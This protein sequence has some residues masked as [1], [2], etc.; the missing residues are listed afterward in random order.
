M[1][2]LPPITLDSDVDPSD[3]ISA[4][5]FVNRVNWLFEIWDVDT[6]VEAFQDPA[7]QGTRCPHLS[8]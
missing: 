6:M 5:D 2:P 1:S 8:T 4:I 7:P 3:R